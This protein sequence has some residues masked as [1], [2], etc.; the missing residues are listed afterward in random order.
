MKNEQFAQHLREQIERAASTKGRRFANMT[1]RILE[2]Q[3]RARGLNFR[4]H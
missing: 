3:R 2:Q 4:F 1:R